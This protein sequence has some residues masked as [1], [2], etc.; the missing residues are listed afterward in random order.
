MNHINSTSRFSLGQ[1]VSTPGCIQ[2]L[3]QAGQR[4]Q[5]FLRRHIACDW[6]DDLCEEDR[7]AND[8]ALETGARLLS[9]GLHSHF[10]RTLLFFVA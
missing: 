6:G 7:A 3:E 9:T 1:I 5:E 2:A 4:P 10:S 8:E